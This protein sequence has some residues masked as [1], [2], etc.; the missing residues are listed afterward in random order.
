M[1][2]NMG[3]HLEFILSLH[4]LAPSDYE[5]GVQ[6]GLSFTSKHGLYVSLHAFWALLMAAEL[7]PF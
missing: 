5:E 3:Y 2:R 1:D 6:A 7:Q 4:A